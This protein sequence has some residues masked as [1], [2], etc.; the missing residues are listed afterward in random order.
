[1]AKAYNSVN[2]LDLLGLPSSSGFIERV[3]EI[4]FVDKL[5]G[6]DGFAAVEKRVVNNLALR[7]YAGSTIICNVDLIVCPF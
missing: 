5:R 1:M 7:L 2:E 6:S 4:K 3:V